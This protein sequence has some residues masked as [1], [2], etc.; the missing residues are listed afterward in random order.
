MVSITVGPDLQL[1]VFETLRSSKYD[2]GIT[3]TGYNNLDGDQ[4]FEFHCY[5]PFSSFITYGIAF[6]IDVYQHREDQCHVEYDLDAVDVGGHKVAKVQF[7]LDEPEE[8]L[9]VPSLFVQCYDH[10]RGY[11]QEV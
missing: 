11:L 3:P 4:V 1:G 10:R 9:D 5:P 7:L 8:Y 6:F 2:V